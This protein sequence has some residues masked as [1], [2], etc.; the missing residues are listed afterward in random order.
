M[1]IAGTTSETKPSS[2]ASSGQTMPMTPNGSFIASVTWRDLRRMHRAVVLVGL[3]GVVEDAADRRLRPPPLAALPTPVMAREARREFGGARR[4]VLGDVVEHLRA[5]V[6]GGRAPAA[7]LGRGLDGV[8]DVLAVA[9]AGLADRLAA[10]RRA[11]IGVAGI[12]PRLLA[13]DV[14]LGGAVDRGR[15]VDL[16]CRPALSGS[17]AA[18][19]RCRAGQQRLLASRARDIRTG[20]RAR[21]RGRSRSRGSRRSR[22]PRRTG[23]WS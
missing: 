23:W 10:W 15:A 8:A 13:A 17:G 7:G 16:A 19:L 18:T 14:E 1:A 9:E 21:P 2:G 22:R 12:R 3:G 4:Q 20:P 11:P 5:V 6:G